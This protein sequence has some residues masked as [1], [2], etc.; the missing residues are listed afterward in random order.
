MLR[1]GCLYAE[2]QRAL[3]RPRCWN[4]LSEGWAHF[5]CA[6]SLGVTQSDGCGA[7]VL[8]ARVSGEDHSSNRL[9]SPASG[10]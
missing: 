8:H 2:G 5:S 6:F 10:I 7:T 9:Q 1:S 4:L 3:G